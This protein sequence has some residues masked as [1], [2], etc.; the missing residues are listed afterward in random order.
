MRKL[1]TPIILLALL[2]TIAIIPQATL[3]SDP[4]PAPQFSTAYEVIDAVNALRTENGL[5]PYTANATLMLLAQ[6]QAE[7]ILSSGTMTDLSE[8]G[9][10]PFQRALMAGYAVA[11]DIYTGEG[12]FLENIIGGSGMTALQAVEKWEMDKQDLETM[13]SAEFQDIGAGVAVSGY[14]YVYVIDCGFSTQGTPRAFTP[15]PTYKTPVVTAIPNTPNADGSVT[16]I[17]QPNDTLL[18]IAI[19]YNISL[20]D[21]YALNGLTERSVI[22]PEQVLILSSAFT[23][24]P[25]QPT[26]TPT[27]RPTITPWPTSTLINTQSPIPSTPTPPVGLPVSVAGTVAGIIVGTA[28]VVALVVTLLGKKKSG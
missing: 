22:Y 5:T 16:Y 4:A 23:A 10:K 26:G 8:N 14:T 3:A 11:G 25:T 20:T 13:N 6:Q 19:T 17:V 24:T 9:L 2:L 28:L 21:L 1:F 27:T 18:E 7:Y 12:L 15:P